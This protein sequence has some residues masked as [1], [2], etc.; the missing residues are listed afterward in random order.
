MV[1]AEE[2]CDKHEWEHLKTVTLYDEWSSSTIP[3]WYKE[4]YVCRKCKKKK[5]VKY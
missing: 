5:I 1:K 3:S 4:V 2:Q